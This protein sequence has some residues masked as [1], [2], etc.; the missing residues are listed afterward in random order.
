MNIHPIRTKAD[1]KRA[2]HEVSA[3]FNNEP[4]P[5]SEDDDRCEILITLVQA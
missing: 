5:G 3:Y 2:L 1:H 4:G